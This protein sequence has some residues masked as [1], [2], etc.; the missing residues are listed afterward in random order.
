METNDAI[1]FSY[2]CMNEAKWSPALKQRIHSPTCTLHG[3]EEALLQSSVADPSTLGRK[4]GFS[5]LWSPLFLGSESCNFSLNRWI[6]RLASTYWGCVCL[7]FWGY[8]VR[9]SLPYNNYKIWWGIIRRWKKWL[10]AI[11]RIKIRHWM[12]RCRTLNVLINIRKDLYYFSKSR[13]S[14]KVSDLRE[15]LWRFV[16]SII[17]ICA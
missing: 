16:S 7:W 2:S 17:L 10:S 14:G 12:E 5:E 8:F 6:N 4:P 15:Y 3:W 1:E 13:L 9:L 11:I